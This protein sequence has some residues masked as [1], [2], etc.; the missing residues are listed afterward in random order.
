MVGLPSSATAVAAIRVATYVLA[1]LAS[2]LLARLLGPHDRGIL[3]VALL[4]TSLIAL[5]SELGLGSAV[6]ALSRRDRARRRATLM[7]GGV[8]ALATA[9]LG[10]GLASLASAFGALP[11]MD[12]V[13][14]AVLRLALG[15]VVLTSL[16]SVGR[17]ALLE[18]GDLVAAAL[19]HLVQA[20]SLLF[21]VGALPFL[22]VTIHAAVGLF[23]V[24]LFIGVLFTAFAL[25][26]HG[27][28]S[29]VWDRSLLAPL[30]TGGIGAH[31][32]TL[33]L[34]LTYRFDLLLV[35]HL[36][37]PHAAGLYSVAL[38]LSEM[39]RG[40]PEI[41]QTIV[42]ARSS[43]MDIRTVVRDTTRVVILAT[44]IGG[45]GAALLG[46]W[47][48]PL[49]FGA[50]FA[51]AVFPFV[52]LLPGVI[53]LGVSYCV[54]PMLLLQGRVRVSTAA[55]VA[56]LLLMVTLDLLLIPRW[57]LVGAAL[58]SSLAYWL[59]ALLQIR[60]IRRHEPLPLRELVPGRGDLLRL[61]E[62]VNPSARHTRA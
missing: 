62:A 12:G 34:F 21:L 8:L 14:P 35:N 44:A 28:L 29:P 58:V 39:L 52:A 46:Y 45:T 17:Q 18:D 13:P 56:S 30:L 4:G 36:I 26:R 16:L 23:I 61:A 53:G 15:G 43:S 38:T 60:G 51:G 31:L 27:L 10:S 49:V 5:L 57:G 33:A 7:V 9:T 3:A 2:I 41:G 47:L 25:I 59:M 19:S 50:D 20:A 6:F 24:S 37:G 40:L 32:A 48:I 54:S 42:L 55:A 22:G 11:L 1:A